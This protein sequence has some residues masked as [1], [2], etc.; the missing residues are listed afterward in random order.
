[1]KPNYKTG[2]FVTTADLMKTFRKEDSNKWS[3]KLSKFTEIS[4][5]TKPTYHISVL[6]KANN[7]HSIQ[8]PERYNE[9]LLKRTKLSMKKII[10]LCKKRGFQWDPRVALQPVNMTQIG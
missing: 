4:N 10:L 5:E 9:T 6:G 7:S 2:N 3:N 1:M 8:L